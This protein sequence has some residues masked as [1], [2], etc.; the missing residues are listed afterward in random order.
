MALLADAGHNLGDVASLALSLFAFRLA[1][2]KP[3]ASF[4]YGYKKTTILAALV[5]AVLLL[6]TVGTLGFESVQMLMH[7]QPVDGAMAAVVAGIGIAVNV[8]SALFFFR[9]KDH[10]LNTK[11][12]YLHLMSDA[13][14]SFGVVIAGIIISYTHWYW[15]DGVISIVILLVVLASTWSLLTGSLRLSLDAVPGDIKKEEIEEVILRMNGVQSIHHMHIWA[16]STTENALTTHVV[17]NESLNFDQKMKTV[18]DIKHKLSH[19]NIQHATIELEYA[20]IPC[21]DEDC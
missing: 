12:A 15:L 17:L 10:D 3:S 9:N 16:M 8:V 13:L 2:W 7:P 11:G 4:T 20:D 18:H 5:N 21:H 6:L 14:V 19:L 1:K